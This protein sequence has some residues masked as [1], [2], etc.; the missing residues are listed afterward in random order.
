M[1][2]ATNTIRWALARRLVE[3][4]R[5][6]RVDDAVTTSGDATV[7]SATATFGIGDVGRLVAGTNV[8]I[9]T[10]IVSVTSATSIELSTPATGSDAAGDLVIGKSGLYVA[11]GATSNGSTTITSASAEFTD[12]DIGK[13]ISGTGIPDLARIATV[14]SLTAVELDIAA[15]ANGTGIQ[16][17]IGT[18]LDGVLVEPGWPGDRATDE[19]VWI[20]ELDGDVVIPVMTAGRKHRDDRFTI[21]FEIRVAGKGDLDS[22]M[23]RVAEILAAIEDEFADDPGVDEF[24]G[25]IDAV[26]DSERMTGGEIANT[27]WVGFGEVVV[28][29]HARYE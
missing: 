20:D 27:G 22:T 11:D 13:P 18:G 24:T 5:V 4:L 14:T 2:A 6:R 26:V 8:P 17:R 28:G 1:V 16:L 29:C 15:T 12:D 9:G 21:P 7:T 19:I 25:L 3:R 10:T 23:C